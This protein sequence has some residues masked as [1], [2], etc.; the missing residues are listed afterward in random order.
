MMAFGVI[1][2]VGAGIWYISAITGDSTEASV[3]AAEIEDNYPSIHRVSVADAKA[4][5]DIGS[6]VFI[7]VRDG[8]EY[9][10]S[11]IPGALSIPLADLPSRMNELDASAWI[12]PY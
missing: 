1:L 8:N 6:A 12:I 9:A 2:I 3:P 11:H 10:I 4:A 7:D 5:Y